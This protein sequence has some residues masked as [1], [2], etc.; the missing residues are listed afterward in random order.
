ME[1][2]PRIAERHR[3]RQT[4]QKQS[5]AQLLSHAGRTFIFAQNRST[6]APQ[7]S[8]PNGEIHNDIGYFS[9]DKARKRLVFRQFRVEG[10]VTQYAASTE[11]FDGN[12]LVLNSETIE[13]IP[14]SWRR[15]HVTQSFSC[16]LGEA[17]SMQHS[18]ASRIT[19]QKTSASL[20]HPVKAQQVLSA[21]FSKLREA[22]HLLRRG[23]K[24][25]STPLR[26]RQT[27]RGPSSPLLT[28][29]RGSRMSHSS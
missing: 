26:F 3:R 1:E 29:P 2:I 10:F 4:W 28:K 9:L 23:V 17:A 8:K 15:S 12:T 5:R 22:S 19:G 21:H 20:C 13:N 7:N 16:S 18:I 24:T 6:Y 27:A 11:P 25:K 14:I